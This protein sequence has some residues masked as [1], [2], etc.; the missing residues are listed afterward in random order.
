MYFNSMR[1]VSVKIVYSVAIIVLT[2]FNLTPALDSFDTAYYLLAG[3]KL[4]QGEIDCLRTPVYPLLLKICSL[5]WGERG[6]S[7]LVT[8]LQS[9]VFLVSVWA[10]YDMLHRLVKREAIVFWCSLYYAVIPAS[11]W[12][13]EMLTESLS[14]SLMVILT[15]GLVCYLQ[16]PN[17]KQALWINIL[18][19]TMVFLRPNFIAFFAIIPVVIILKSLNR[20][21]AKDRC[22]RANYGAIL[23]F[24]LIPVGSYL[25]YCKAYENKYGTFA[26]IMCDTYNLQ[27]GGGW[28]SE[29]VTNPDAK[30]LCMDLDK[31][32][33]K[34][35]A[36]VYKVI[37]TTHRA[38]LLK[39]A[40][41]DMRA[42]HRREYISQKVRMISSGMGEGILPAVNTHS[43][44]SVLLFFGS[45]TMAMPVSF[46]YFLTIVGCIVL[47]IHTIKKRS[48]PVTA[49][50]L[51][52][53]LLAQVAGITAAASDSLWRHFSILVPI[54]LAMIG[55]GVDKMFDSPIFEYHHKE[56]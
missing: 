15:R 11:G 23:L 3:E 8:I 45:K 37:N 2:L 31:D 41:L 39:E 16:A 49:T 32:Q 51:V 4:W 26:P 5:P 22:F 18:L 42:I 17:W 48:I 34:S 10:F 33:D 35:Y 28:D 43:A 36:S 1:K 54:M 50:L 47:I 14:I 27:R 40:C 30:L 20:H 38:D 13:N 55:M 6:M 21:P 29:C 46:A 12:A 7:V 56:Q 24:L 53:I 52:S 19:T 25:G 44:L 9:A